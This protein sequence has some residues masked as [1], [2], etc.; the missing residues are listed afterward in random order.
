M[1]DIETPPGQD[2]TLLGYLANLYQRG[3]R[4]YAAEEI[5]EAVIHGDELAAIDK[6][7]KICITVLELREAIV[8][9]LEGLPFKLLDL[10]DFPDQEVKADEMPPPVPIPPSA[11]RNEGQLR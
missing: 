8:N 2:S 11:E 5:I 9:A 3:M 6:S 1:S 4:E 7:T 10:N